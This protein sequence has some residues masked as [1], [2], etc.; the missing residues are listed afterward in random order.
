MFRKDFVEKQLEQMGLVISKLIGDFLDP[1]QNI[2]TG[3]RMEKVKETLKSEFDLEPDELN[4]IEEQELIGHLIK[5]KQLKTAQLNLLADLLFATIPII[6]N[7]EIPDPAK[8]LI[9]KIL[10][11]YEYVNSTEK[12]FSEA[13]E[14][15]I[16]TLKSKI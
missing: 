1:E 9:P 10:T 6:E 3:L 7:S 2:S 8:A 12:T 16:T 14:Q 13:R 4:T 5:N 11:I 15:K